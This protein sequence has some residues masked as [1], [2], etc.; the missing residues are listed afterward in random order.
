MLLIPDDACNPNELNE[1]KELARFL[2]ELSVCDYFFVQYTSMSIG[3]ASLLV[4]IELIDAIWKI[5]SMEAFLI[6]VSSV[7]GCDYE[8]M[9]ILECKV[10][11]QE[12]YMH[13]EFYKQQEPSKDR[14]AGDISPACVS[15]APV[16]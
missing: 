12:T 14:S 9:D 4:A 2:T 3:M 11:L 8:S 15:N 16:S 7:A 13:G 1:I 10:R 5:G 6:Q